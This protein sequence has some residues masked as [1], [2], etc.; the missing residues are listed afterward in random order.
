MKGSE[1]TMILYFTGTGNRLSMENTVRSLTD[2]PARNKK[3]RP[4]P[5]E[6][7]SGG[8]RAAEHVGL[9]DQER[10]A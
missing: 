5:F 9:F 1:N 4:S 8:F 10:P 7:R 6:K 3:N 2:T